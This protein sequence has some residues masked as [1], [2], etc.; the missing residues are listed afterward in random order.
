LSIVFIRIGEKISVTNVEKRIDS[1]FT[2]ASGD[3][4]PRGVPTPREIQKTNCTMAN[5]STNI[6]SL[7]T[8]LDAT[9][10]QDLA[11]ST[12]AGKKKSPYDR[13]RP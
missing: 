6:R 11:G 5:L 4:A 1:N 8:G 2:N 13:R 3:V 7:L 10:P 9:E 12:S